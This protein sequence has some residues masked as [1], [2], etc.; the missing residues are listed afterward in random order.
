M[1]G[2]DTLKPD[3]SFVDYKKLYKETVTVEEVCEN[4]Y[5]GG[6]EIRYWYECDLEKLFNLLVELNIID[7]EEY[8]E[9]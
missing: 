8:K 4:D 7:N 1:S 3:I 2:C 5:Y 6:R 9:N